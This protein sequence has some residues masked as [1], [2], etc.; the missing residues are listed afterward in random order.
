MP[1]ERRAV[2]QKIDGILDAAVDK[3][4]PQPMQGLGRER[5]K[6]GQFGVR[7]VVAGKKR[8]RDA[9]HPGER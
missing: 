2:A 8:Q 1:D 6:P 9:A 3:I 5:G 4:L 7:L